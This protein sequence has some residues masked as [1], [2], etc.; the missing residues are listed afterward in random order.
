MRRYHATVLTVLAV[1]ISLFITSCGNDPFFHHVKVIVNGRTISEELV[2]DGDSFVLPEWNDTG[3]IFE[4]WSVD[5]DNTHYNPR[6]AIKILRDTTI[7]AVLK[8]GAP[9]ITLPRDNSY[10]GTNETLVIT[11]TGGGEVYYTTDGSTPTSSGTKGTEIDLKNLETGNYT[12]KAIVIKDGVSS[13]IASKEIIVVNPPATPEISGATEIKEQADSLTVTAVD[14]TTVYYTTDNTSP[15]KESSAATEGK[16]PLNGHSGKFTLKVIRY[17]NS[18]GVPSDIQSFDISVRPLA[19][20]AESSMK[21]GKIAESGEI[22]L[23]PSEGATIRYTIDSED[24]SATQGKEG[25]VISMKDY[26]LGS[27]ILRFISVKDGIASNVI[28]ISFTVVP[29]PF[30]FKSA[31]GTELTENAEIAQNAVIST[32]AES[33]SDIYYTTDGKTNPTTSSAKADNGQIKVRGLAGKVEIRAI[34]VRDGV[35]SEVVS[36]TIYVNPPKPTTTI[37]DGTKYLKAEGKVTGISSTDGTTLRYK[38]GADSNPTKDSAEVPANG[39]SLSS[40]NAGKVVIKVVAEKDGV[41]SEATEIKVVACEYK[42]TFS[43]SSASSDVFFNSGD[44]IEILTIDS[45][46]T[47]LFDGWYT[48][49]NGGGDKYYEPGGTYTIDGTKSFTLYAHWV[50]ASLAF[51]EKKSTDGKTVIGYE[52]SCGITG[53]T[54]ADRKDYP[55][56]TSTTITIP[57]SYKGKKVIAV[58]ENGFMNCTKLTGVTFENPDSII[59]IGKNAFYYATSFKDI[60]IPGKVKEIG[61]KAFYWTAIESATVPLTVT[62]LGTGVFDHCQSL[63]TAEIRSNITELPVDTFLY[64]TSLTSLTLPESLE[65]IGDCALAHCSA[66]TSGGIKSTFSKVKKVGYAAF[67]EDKLLTEISLPNVEIIDF[68]SGSYDSSCAFQGCIALKKIDLPKVKTIGKLAFDGCTAL[69]EVTIGSDVTSIGDETFRGCSSLKSVYISRK[70]KDTTL[71]PTKWSI[72]DASGSDN[73]TNVVEWHKDFTLTFYD[74][75]KTT[76]KAKI[77]FDAEEDITMP[78]VSKTGYTLD[79]W[80]NE[81]GTFYC[82]D[83]ETITKITAPGAVG[84]EVKVYAKWIEGVFK[85]NKISYTTIS[86]TAVSGYEISCGFTVTS[87]S[88]QSDST[89]QGTITIPAT[90]HG[91]EKVIAIADEGFKNCQKITSVEFKDADSIVSLGSGAF[92]SCSSLTAFAIPANVEKLGISI[93]SSC[94]SLTSVTFPANCKITIIPVDAFIASGLTS[95]TLPENITEIGSCAFHTTSLANIVIPEKVTKIGD[96]AF[97]NCTKL[98]TVE[99]GENIDTIGKDTFKNCSALESVYIDRAQKSSDDLTSWNVDSSKVIWRKAYILAFDSVDGTTASSIRVNA[100]DKITLPAVTKAGYT[101]NGWYNGSA[102]V[103]NAGS[104][105]SMP[106]P[107]EGRTLTLTAKWIEGE[108]KFTDTIV[109]G[110]VCYLIATASTDKT[111]SPSGTLTIP[112][113]YLEK[114]IV[115]VA[116]NGFTGCTAITKVTFAKPGNITIINNN[117]FNSCSKLKEISLPSNLETIGMNAF[118]SCDI[119]GRIV[120][121]KSVTLLGSSA[122]KGNSNLTEFQIEDGSTLTEI[123]TSCFA[124]CSL[125]SLDGLSAGVTELYAKSFS[126]NNFTNLVI[127]STVKKIVGAFDSCKTLVSVRGDGVTSISINSFYECTKLETA[128]FDKIESIGSS[129]FFNCTSL[130]EVTLGSEIQSIDSQAFR[131]AG[132]ITMMVDMNEAD[133]KITGSP[134]YATSVTMIFNDMATATF[135][136]GENVIGV[137]PIDSSGKVSK[138]AEPTKSGYYVAAWLKDDG[139]VF[140]F[141]NETVTGSII[142]TAEWRETHNV[143]DIGPSGGIIFYDAGSAQVSSYVDSTGKAVI[144]AWRY[145]EATP[146]DLSI[147]QDGKEVSLFKFYYYRDPSTGND[148]QVVKSNN[149]AIGTGR[150]NT[151]A[152][153]NAVGNAAYVSESRWESTVTNEIYAAKVCDGFEYGGCKDWF[154]PSKDELEEM[155]NQKSKLGTFNTSDFYCTSSESS[156]STGYMW[157]QYF[158]G[159]GKQTTTNR[160]NK[161]RI[162]PVRAI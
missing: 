144:Y 135:K 33:D 159:V 160:D 126:G 92:T 86:N 46:S 29:D 38:F 121:P 143:G 50:D 78:A 118:E 76:E 58:A 91:G 16:I 110:E 55:A 4:Y 98:K 105:Y 56:G 72:T 17:D 30:K 44:S 115:G 99:I 140:D 95:V 162:R 52:V 7:T 124:N 31:D 1:I 8:A 6:N 19:G 138:P 82:G 3:L 12:V 61:D 47:S 132:A 73:S 90:Y 36:H 157:A 112:E 146:T 49:E 85:F 60:T 152:I 35:E 150:S 149:T 80:Y 130:K 32:T 148:T 66:L 10:M 123:N 71:D 137:T 153:V 18:N 63:E 48:S 65:V 134:W 96:M 113:K 34:A 97:L 67:Y 145:L 133:F 14:N 74:S 53:T 155:Y 37:K 161:V 139:T 20:K 120:I 41:I 25:T 151:R 2:Y 129:A 13:E 106:A 42:L 128:G 101:F 57:A 77:R 125:T 75:D 40:Q 69:E 147:T 104:E 158:D 26:N 84:T 21:G 22:T 68:L 93:F 108:Y 83:Q 43:S 70:Q 62:K 100:G 111:A 39:I 79:G 9:S 28:P 81:N 127:P 51:G 116:A 24:I 11:A 5:G 45:T 156:T 109:G 102:L 103:G 107:A 64:C 59:S 117:A 54:E 23:T 15:T 131:G 141:T 154:L 122:F 89:L 142:L 114:K 119:T 136:D 27:H 94:S 88:R 87:S